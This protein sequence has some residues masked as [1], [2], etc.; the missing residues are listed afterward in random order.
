M[1]ERGESA[2]QARWAGDK[3]EIVAPPSASCAEPPVAVVDKNVDKHGTRAVAEAYLEFLY[4]R[5]GQ[6]IGARHHYRPRDPAVMQPSHAGRVPQACSCSPSTRSFGRLAEGAGDALRRR[7][8]LRP[9]LPA[10]DMMRGVP[11][12]VAVVG[13]ASDRATP[14]Q[15]RAAARVRAVAGR[16][17]EYLCLI[18]LIPLAGLVFKSAVAGRARALAGG[19]V[20]ARAGG[21][22]PQLRRRAGA[23]VVNVVFGLVLAWVLVALRFPGKA[24]LD[25]MVDLPFA[26]PTAVAGIALTALFAEQAA[27]SGA[28]SSRTASRSRSRRRAW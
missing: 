25:A 17:G 28:S 2:G 8:H 27:G 24:L 26:L 12:E 14:R 3:F 23:G 22:S 19:V 7:R 9:D 11:A 18:V 15:P 6:E 5:E 4:T 10:G 21:V 1:G 13:G 16:D 20:A